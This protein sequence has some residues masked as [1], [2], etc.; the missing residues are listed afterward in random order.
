M[1]ITQTALLGIAGFFIAGLIALA[2]FRGHRGGGILL[3]IICA[4]FLVWLVRRARERS[5]GPGAGGSMNRWQL[6]P[7]GRPPNSSN[8]R[9]SPFGLVH[10]PL[11]LPIQRL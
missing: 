11:C 2:L 5:G 10:H 3:S 6:S 4:M 7:D 1:T 8:T 9:S